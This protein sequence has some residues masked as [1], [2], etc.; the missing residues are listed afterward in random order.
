MLE[1]TESDPVVNIPINYVQLVTVL[2]L[3]LQYT[4]TTAI[5]LTTIGLLEHLQC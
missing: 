5:S 1:A 2:A 4:V 3:V